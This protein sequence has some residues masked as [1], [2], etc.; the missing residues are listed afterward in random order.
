MS[1][2]ITIGRQYGSGGRYIAREL[3]K[4]LKI[5]FYDNELLIKAAERTG[6][7]VDYIK[8]NEE[9]KGFDFCFY[10]IK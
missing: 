10:G 3:A 9:K 2:V 4:K 1:Y 6:F 7:S 5:N 8:A